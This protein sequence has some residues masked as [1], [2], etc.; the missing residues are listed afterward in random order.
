RSQI[1]FAGAR[2]RNTGKENSENRARTPLN[3]RLPN[4]CGCKGQRQREQ[5]ACQ[6]HRAQPK[7]VRVKKQDL[8]EADNVFHESGCGLQIMPPLMELICPV[9]YAASSD[10]RN[11]TRFATS[12]GL[13]ARFA[14]TSRAMVGASKISLVISDSIIPGATAF[15]VMPRL[16]NSRDSDFVAAFNAPLAAA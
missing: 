6:Q 3:K 12:S 14:G 11:A 15:T 10:A 2:Q 4:A 13:P 1:E 8:D 16:A 7:Q 9:M 5:A